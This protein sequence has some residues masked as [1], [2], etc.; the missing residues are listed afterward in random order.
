[1]DYSSDIMAYSAAASTCFFD[2]ATIIAECT[3]VWTTFAIASYMVFVVLTYAACFNHTI[4]VI[5]ITGHSSS[6]STSSPPRAC[7][8]YNPDSGHH[9]GAQC[10]TGLHYSHGTHCSNYMAHCS[11]SIPRIDDPTDTTAELTVPTSYPSFPTADR[12]FY[13]SSRRTSTTCSQGRPE[14]SIREET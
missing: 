3:S 2:V 4:L 13:I 8:A 9:H 11:S 12:S 1:M 5:R 7:N 14:A 10:S 6:C